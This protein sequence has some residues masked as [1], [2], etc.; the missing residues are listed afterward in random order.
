[1]GPGN[2]SLL[3][4]DG[5][6]HTN[7]LTFLYLPNSRCTKISAAHKSSGNFQIVLET[8]NTHFEGLWCNYKQR[9]LAKEKILCSDNEKKRIERFKIDL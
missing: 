4:F 6:C 3:G 8:E 7:S 2:T 1:M 9:N 5:N